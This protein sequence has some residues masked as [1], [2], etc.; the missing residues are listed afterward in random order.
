MRH[1][2]L[3]LSAVLLLGL[4]LTGLQAQE[5]IIAA[6]G[7]A[8]GSD[9]SV[10]YTV[11]QI[12]YQTFTDI[13]GSVVQGVQQSYEIS[14][15]IEG[16]KGINLSIRAYPNP[17]IGYLILSIDDFDISNLSYQMYDMQGK[18]LQ[19]EK[20]TSNRTSIIMNEL[21]PSTYFVK[22]IQNNKEIKTLK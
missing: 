22:V 5:S 17:S 14:V 18:L 11:G 9:G 2:R 12:V 15:G 19:S 20:I 1:K 13:S 7:N 21:V 3:T 8:T 16:P 10:S 4:G 6:G